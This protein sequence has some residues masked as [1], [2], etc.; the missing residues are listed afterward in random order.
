MVG[1]LSSVPIRNQRNSVSAQRFERFFGEVELIKVVDA[2]PADLIVFR[3]RDVG[4][5]AGPFGDHPGVKREIWSWVVDPEWLRVLD[6]GRHAE[7][8]STL[9]AYGIGW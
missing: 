6:S 4:D 2:E 3:R 7:F 1:R 9:S 5:F 8:F